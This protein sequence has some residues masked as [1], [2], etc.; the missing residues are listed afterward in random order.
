M[1]EQYCEVKGVS[2]VPFVT[3]F[4]RGYGRVLSIDGEIV[5]RSTWTNHSAMD[6]QPTFISAVMRIGGQV[7]THMHT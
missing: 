7:C 5:R 6:R 4:G 1:L 2:G 3:S